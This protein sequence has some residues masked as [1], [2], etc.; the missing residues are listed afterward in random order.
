[1]SVINTNVMSLNAQR[2]L[3]ANSADLGTT[4]QRLSSGLRINSAKDDA[5]GL[6]ISQRFTTQIRGMDQ[7][8]RNANDGISLA[9]T[10]EG[11]M[12]EIGNNLQRIRE[13]AVQSANATNSSDD[14]AALQKEVNQ[15]LSEIDRVADT[16]NFNGTK[17]LNGDAS[18]FVFQVGANAGDTITVDSMI[19]ANIAAL[20]GTISVST[21]ES[22]GISGLGTGAVVAGSLTINGTDIGPLDAVGTAS[23]RAAQVANAINHV[24]T[25]TGVNA[26]INESTGKL[27]LSSG[28]TITMGGTDDGTLTGFDGAGAAVST[29]ATH[30]G[31]ATLDISSYAGAEL[32][33]KQIDAAMKE[34]NDGRADL[35]AVQNRFSSV[36]TNLQT[37]SE[38]LS[39]ARSRIMDADYAK[40]T[41][42][43]SRTQILAQAGTAMLAQANQVPQNV[44]SLLR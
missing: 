26:R 25:E 3:G 11:A 15:L 28:A 27:E 24:S 42:N 7:A 13:L 29:D 17:L 40:E 23:Q 30:T 19:D 16:T 36:V 22:S 8:A 10:A 39:A 5:A 12:G 1:M 38:N 35:G 2:N 41:A 33:M 37:S 9:Q 43:L 31:I 18:S 44:L 4:I 34:V 21:A 32:A 6:A 20:G 14:R